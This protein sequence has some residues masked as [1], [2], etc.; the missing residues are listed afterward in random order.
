MGCGA[1]KRSNS[2]IEPAWPP[3][4]KADADELMVAERSEIS[5]PESIFWDYVRPLTPVKD[6]VVVNKRCSTGFYAANRVTLD[7]SYLKRYERREN[8]VLVHNYGIPFC[9]AGNEA[10]RFRYLPVARGQ[11]GTNQFH[12][13][14]GGCYASATR[15]GHFAT[16]SEVALEKL[17]SCRRA[18]D[19]HMSKI[20]F[21]YMRLRLCLETLNSCGKYVSFLFDGEGTIEDVVKFHASV[22]PLALHGPESGLVSERVQHGTEIFPNT[23][24]GY[25]VTRCLMNFHQEWEARMELDEGETFRCNQY[26]EESIVQALLDAGAD[27]SAFFEPM[28]FHPLFEL[29]VLTELEEIGRGLGPSFERGMSLHELMRKY[30]LWFKQHDHIFGCVCGFQGIVE[31]LASKS[32]IMLRFDEGSWVECNVGCHDHNLWVTGFVAGQWVDGQPYIVVVQLD[33]GLGG[34]VFIP[35]DEDTYIRRPALRFKVGDRV[36]CYLNEAD[37]WVPGKVAEQWPGLAKGHP[38][39]I[40]L[41]EDSLLTISNDKDFLIRAPIE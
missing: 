34:C 22:N 3:K 14:I 25:W 9:D 5:L 19:E 18:W 38:Y 10:V 21:H 31:S 24:L 7:E 23:Q 12:V 17:R 6:R 16:D 27:V 37:G 2:I 35:T 36:E 28:K 29:S 33:E 40:L 20:P 1:S 13:M 41:E 32:N 8:E 4:P 30:L 15:D 39:A 11:P 26:G